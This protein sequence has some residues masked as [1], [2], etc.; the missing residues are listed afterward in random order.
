MVVYRVGDL[1][2]SL[3][4]VV[5]DGN[6]L[7]DLTTLDVYVRWQKPDGSLIAER[8]AAPDGDQTANKG[9]AFYAWQAGDLSI[10]GVY[11]A[12][13]QLSPDGN[14]AQRYSL[15]NPPLTEIEVLANDFA[16][17]DTTLLLP[18]PSGYD[19]AQL[20]HRDPATMDGNLLSMSIERGRTMAYA[21]AELWRCP[22]LVLDP[23]GTRMARELVAELAAQAYVTNPLVAY[24][25]YKKETF[26]SYSYEMKEG[27]LLGTKQQSG[28]KTGI[29]A[30]DAMIAYL[31]WLCYGCQAA[32][33]DVIYPDWVQPVTERTLDPALPIGYNIIPQ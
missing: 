18:Y 27:N 30:L 5:Q 10:P 17:L 29:P 3:G 26:G 28:G 14:P 33:I 2:P 8:Q 32:G 24:G 12:I 25:P 1:L 11:R 20:L 6:S 7:T 15:T 13:I 16:G 22:G 9:L 19:V 31:G 21:Y 23:I 4:I